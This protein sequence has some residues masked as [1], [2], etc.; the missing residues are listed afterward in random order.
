MSLL[1]FVKS[2][3]LAQNNFFGNRIAQTIFFQT[4]VNRKSG[5]NNDTKNI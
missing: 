4:G 1:L 5:E 2:D 3:D